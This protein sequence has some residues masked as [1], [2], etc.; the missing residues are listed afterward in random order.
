[1]PTLDVE[2]AHRHFS[3]HCFNE[4]WTLLDKS[5]DRTDDESRLMEA[6]AFASLYHWLQRPDATPK[7]LSVGYWQVSRVMSMLERGPEALHYAEICLAKSG[8]LPPFYR[9]YAI[10]AIAR[11]AALLGQADRVQT[12]K[13]AATELLPLMTDADERSMLEGDLQTI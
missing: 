1:M 11:S 2:A 4:T 9:G 10:E 12:A 13:S 8:D 6:A 7:N 3:T 5:K